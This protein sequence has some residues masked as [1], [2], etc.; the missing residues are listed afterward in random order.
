VDIN[1]TLFVQMLTFG[2][3]VL[4]TKNFVWPH[5]V[6]ALDERKKTIANGLA[7]AEKGKRDLE[8]AQR[9]VV[10]LLRESKIQ[11]AEIVDA[12]NKRAN[13]IVEDAKKDAR[14]EG[15]RLMGIAQGDIAKEV[16]NAKAELRKRVGILAINGAEKI[17]TK[18][19]DESANRQLID[20]LM[21]EL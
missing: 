4:F 11:G 2:F 16:Q 7:A 1:A 5:I 6:G 17:L 8:F 10:E 13:K 21:E 19:I 14:K 9:K 12:A 20:E 3:F 18:E 15:D